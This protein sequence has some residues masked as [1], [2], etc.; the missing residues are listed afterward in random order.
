MADVWPV[1]RRVLVVPQEEGSVVVTIQE[2]VFLRTTPDN[3]IE[4]TKLLAPVSSAYTP[5]ALPATMV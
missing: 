2:R 3:V 4:A 1:Q 5:K